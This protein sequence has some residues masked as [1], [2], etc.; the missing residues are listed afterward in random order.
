M[1]RY[2][3]EVIH[4][5]R[6]CLLINYPSH[7]LGREMSFYFHRQAL[8][9]LL[10]MH[11]YMPFALPFIKIICLYNSTDIFIE[12]I[13]CRYW[14]KSLFPW[15]WGYRQVTYIISGHKCC[16]AQAGVLGCIAILWR[17]ALSRELDVVKE[18]ARQR[19]ERNNGSE[20][21][22][23]LACWRTR[24]VNV[25]EQWVRGWEETSVFCFEFS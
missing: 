19:T 17:M 4:P 20:K 1:G 15:S 7:G 3:A 18:W 21:A 22:L 2:L 25:A 5:E 14:Y 6:C 23:N 11:V 12:L 24:K 8:E 13:Y 9:Y 16:K 10:S